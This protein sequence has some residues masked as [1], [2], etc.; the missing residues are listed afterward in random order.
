[1]SQ[2]L[3]FS[4][5]LDLLLKL[6]DGND[7]TSQELCEVIGTTRRNLYYYLEFFQKYGFYL[8]KEGRRY[9]FDPRSPFFQ[10]IAP[11][12][13]FSDSEAAYLYKLVNAVERGNAYTESIRNK[14]RRLYDLRQLTD[15]KVRTHQLQVVNALHEA[16]LRKRVVMLCNYSSPHSRS[17]SNRVVEPFMLMNDDNDVRC[18]ELSSHMNKTFKVS[19]IGE[20]R[21]VDDVEWSHEYMHK[22]IFTD[23][24]MFSGEERLHVVLRLGQLARN[25][26]VEEFPRAAKWLTPEDETHWQLHIDVANFA[27]LGRFVLGL[28]QDVEVVENDDFRNYLREQ[29]E[30][31]KF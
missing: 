21:I 11:T 4:R 6:I 5:L 13:S 29:V 12:V 24:F 8:L 19:R 14:L 15:S 10:Q 3:Q 17:V 25:L 28:A 31:M 2:Q 9:R 26:L 1:M 30:K 27:G 23:I 20:V 16:M 22:K 18:Y 7:Y